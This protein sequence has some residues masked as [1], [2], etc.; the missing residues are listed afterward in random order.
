MQARSVSSDTDQQKGLQ[1]SWGWYMYIEASGWLIS[2]LF[3]FEIH[4]L[5]GVYVFSQLNAGPQILT[6]GINTDKR[7]SC[8][9]AAF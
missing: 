3:E 2:S 1:I 6:P 8:N 9:T 5:E 7:G 4:K